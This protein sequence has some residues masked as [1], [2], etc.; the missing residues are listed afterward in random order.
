MCKSRFKG[1]ICKF[2]DMC[3]YDSWDKTSAFFK[4]FI[5]LSANFITITKITFKRTTGANNNE[6]LEGFICLIDRIDV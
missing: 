4:L 1:N 3:K 5:S 6:N 2:E